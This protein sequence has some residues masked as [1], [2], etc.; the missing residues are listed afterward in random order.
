MFHAGVTQQG[1]FELIPAHIITI[2]QPNSNPSDWRVVEVRHYEPGADSHRHLLGVTVLDP[3]TD[4]Q[5]FL[6]KACAFVAMVHGAEPPMT[7][8]ANSRLGRELH[9]V[10]VPIT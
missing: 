3:E 1:K 8:V 5:P 6:I 9:A 7:A 10:G 4:K 2:F